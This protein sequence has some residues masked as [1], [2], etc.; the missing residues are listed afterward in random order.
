[1][2]L[3]RKDTMRVKRGNSKKLRKDARAENVSDNIS[4]YLGT[5]DPHMFLSVHRAC[6]SFPPWHY[7]LPVSEEQLIIPAPG[8]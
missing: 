2:P 6:S 4:V 8:V 1:M 3:H 7:H 5:P